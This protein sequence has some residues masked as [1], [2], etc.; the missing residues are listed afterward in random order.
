MT[1]TAESTC[2]LKGEIQKLKTMLI[3]VFRQLDWM[4]YLLITVRF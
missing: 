2:L 4:T 1:V 3:I